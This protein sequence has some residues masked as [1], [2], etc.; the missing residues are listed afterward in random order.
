MT[1]V[2]RELIADGVIARVCKKCGQEKP[3]AEYREYTYG[4]RGSG[5][6]FICTVC[7]P[8]EKTAGNSAPRGKQSARNAGTRYRKT[9]GEIHGVIYFALAESVNRIKIG[10]SASNV[11]KRIRALQTQSPVEITLLGYIPGTVLDEQ[12]LHIKFDK[13][14]VHHE[15]FNASKEIM[16]FVQTVLGNELQKAG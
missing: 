16:D 10:H 12:N 3:L 6:T 5:E 15:W 2:K 13:F 11:E 14:R 1:N 9:R 4:G 8:C 7:R